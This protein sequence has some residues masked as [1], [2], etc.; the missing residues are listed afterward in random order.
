[1]D[2]LDNDHEAWLERW[3]EGRT[4]FHL[5]RT[6][7]Q[8][9]RHI[10]RV[11]APGEGRVFVPLCGKSLDLAWLVDRGHDVVG[12]ELAE[13]AVRAFHR[14]HDLEPEVME[15]A[16]FR[17]YTS[18]RLSLYVGD[19]FDLGRAEV[20]PF[21]VIWDRAAMI[22]LRLPVRR[23][24]VAHLRRLLAPGGRILLST[25]AYDQDRMEGPPF[26]VPADE[27]SDAYGDGFSIER[28]AETDI[29]AEN[30]RFAAS[31]LGRVLEETWVL[32]PQG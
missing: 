5:D 16:S 19:F 8:L 14:E 25:L 12:V 9:V 1:M 2:S 31:G 6:N 11:L 30:P 18:H 26:S 29:T 10:G 32:T 24:Y 13:D 4:G 7:E 17:V 23:S 15:T 20:Q 28:V 22:A 27:V 21:D 3:R